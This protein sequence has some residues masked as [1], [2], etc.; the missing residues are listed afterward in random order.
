MPLWVDVA[1]RVSRVCEG[2]EGSRQMAKPHR[3]GPG[4]G[5]G[6]RESR[7]RFINIA[8]FH[9]LGGCGLQRTF[10]TTQNHKS[11]GFNRT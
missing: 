11:L 3:P 5:G 6:G 10:T 8:G 9:G 4:R 2:E 1:G 7:R